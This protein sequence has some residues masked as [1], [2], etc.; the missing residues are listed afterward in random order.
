MA[1]ETDFAPLPQTLRA[2]ADRL[3]NALRRYESV[4]VAMSAGV[5]STVVAKAAALALEDRAVAVTASSASV[6][7]AEI[8]QAEELAR[9]IGIRHVVLSTNEF[10]S[11]LYVANAPDRCFHC[12]TELYGGIA[13]AQEQLGFATI[14]NGAN[15]DD[16]GDHRPGMRAAADLNVQSPL[17]DCGFHKDD[18]RALARFWNLPVWDKPASPC[19]SSR[20]A[21]GVEVTP[22]R[23]HRVE[24]AEAFLKERFNLRELRVRHEAGDLARI[25]VQPNRIPDLAAPE[26]SQ[27]ITRELTSLGFKFV[28]IDL[29][30]F[31]SGSLN[32]VV[33]VE[34]LRHHNGA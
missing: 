18:I 2:K 12:K 34:M 7:R 25:E 4:A 15:A 20:I 19:L 31:R 5:D 14:V 11:P 23:T 8:E 3:L 28:T 30:G 1:S 27:E 29:A 6:P 26:A 9:L 22:E 24:R 13:A 32:A 10:D 21:Y 17:L 16:L 33:P